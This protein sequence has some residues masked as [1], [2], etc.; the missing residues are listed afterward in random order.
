MV[1]IATK[2]VV[3][4]CMTCS[5]PVPGTFILGGKKPAMVL[6]GAVESP[7]MFSMRKNL[8]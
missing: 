1:T 5:D 4:N 2:D 3:T 8:V 7:V 6:V